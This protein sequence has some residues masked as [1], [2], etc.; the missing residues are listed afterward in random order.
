MVPLQGIDPGDDEEE[1]GEPGGDEGDEEETP[2]F[3]HGAV[4]LPGEAPVGGN[5]VGEV[6]PREDRDAE[7]EGEDDGDADPA[8]VGLHDEYGP[9]TLMR[10]GRAP[11][12]QVASSGWSARIGP[13]FA[14]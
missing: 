12:S 13:N 8:P 2:G 10:V 3:R 9:R 5:G 4:R 7:G 6:R 11:S 14:S 1:E